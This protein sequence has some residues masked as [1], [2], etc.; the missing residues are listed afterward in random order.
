[1]FGF[2]HFA[3][4]FSQFY[5]NSP[6]FL[7]PEASHHSH[8]I[9]GM[10]LMVHLEMLNRLGSEIENLSGRHHGSAVHTVRKT[11]LAEPFQPSNPR[12]DHKCKLI[13]ILVKIW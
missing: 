12:R 11:K 1:M 8:K 13:I 7:M 10:G 3:H 5:R 9:Q 6:K 2:P 4:D